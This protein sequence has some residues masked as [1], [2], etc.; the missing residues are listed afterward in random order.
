MISPT[1]KNTEKIGAGQVM[2]QVAGPQ[3]DYV[4]IPAVTQEVEVVEE[5]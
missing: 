1:K 5:S 2:D 3:A 4:G